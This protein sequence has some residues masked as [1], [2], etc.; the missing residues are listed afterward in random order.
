MSTNLGFGLIVKSA[1]C[2]GKHADWY[3]YLGAQEVE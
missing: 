2:S 3:H 1:L